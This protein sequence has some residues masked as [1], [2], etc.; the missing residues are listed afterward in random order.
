MIY[1]WSSLSSADSFDYN[2][3]SVIKITTSPPLPSHSIHRS[4]LD[5]TRSAGNVQPPAASYS[6]TAKMDNGRKRQSIIALDPA[7]KV[8][9]SNLDSQF[10][11]NRTIKKVTFSSM[12]YYPERTGT[13]ISVVAKSNVEK[14]YTVLLVTMLILGVVIPP[15]WITGGLLG[16]F[17]IRTRMYEL[18]RDTYILGT[19]NHCDL[20]FA[21][22]RDENVWLVLTKF[23]GIKFWVI[24]SEI[25]AIVALVELAL[26]VTL[27]VLVTQSSSTSAYGQ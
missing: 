24:L 9:P 3:I 25:F 18:E 26:I 2:D 1:S 19:G 21:H 8:E 22:K 23:H 14:Q 17:V 12:P 13:S 15:F 20:Q 7:L 11:A 4:L 16:H 10:F 27:A 5:A 6:R